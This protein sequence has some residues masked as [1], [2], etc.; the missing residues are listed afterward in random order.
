MLARGYQ[1]DLH[2]LAD[3]GFLKIVA[4]FRQLRPTCEDLATASAANNIPVM[5]KGD[6]AVVQLVNDCGKRLTN[7]INLNNKQLPEVPG[8]P[9]A[10]VI[11]PNILLPANTPPW[12]Q[13]A[14]AIAVQNAGTGAPNAPTANSPRPAQFKPAQAAGPYQIPPSLPNLQRP[15]QCPLPVSGN[16]S[17]S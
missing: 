1:T 15:I 13:W 9:P 3:S 11:V 8:V 5:Q 4:G 16:L 2:H 6:T 14:L 7:T 17:L 12:S 10:Q